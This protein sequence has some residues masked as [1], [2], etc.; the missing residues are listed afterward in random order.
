MDNL[1]LDNNVAVNEYLST[2]KDTTVKVIQ[3]DTGGR[4][5]EDTI[6]TGDILKVK[7]PIRAL[8][9]KSVS[10]WV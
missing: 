9:F 3:G 5:S 6:I 4:H 8:A 10:V 2:L 1:N 7:R